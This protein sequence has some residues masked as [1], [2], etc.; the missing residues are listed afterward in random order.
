LEACY[1][2]A[3]GADLTLVTACPFDMSTTK[4]QAAIKKFRAS[5]VYRL[6]IEPDE[7]AQ[8]L[9]L[10]RAKLLVAAMSM[11]RA[12]LPAREG[13]PMRDEFPCTYCDFKTLCISDGPEFGIMFPPIPES[14]KVPVISWE[15]A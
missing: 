5:P 3:T 15:A 10:L 2:L 11:E 8:Q 13:N 9:G 7:Q 12:G 14:M 6:V 1:I 4:Q